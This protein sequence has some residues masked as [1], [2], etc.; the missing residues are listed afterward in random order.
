MPQWRVTRP[1]D[2]A[3]LNSGVFIAVLRRY[4]A[5]IAI[6]APIYFA[7]VVIL[8]ARRTPELGVGGILARIWPYF[9]S[10]FVGRLLLALVAAM[11]IVAIYSLIRWRQIL[12]F[13]GPSALLSAFASAIR[14]LIIRIERRVD[15]SLH[16][17]PFRRANESTVVPIHTLLD[18]LRACL[19]IAPA[20]P[21]LQL[22]L[23]A[24]RS[25]RP[26]QLILRR[27]A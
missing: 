1:V 12:A 8:G 14:R 18:Q 5:L 15:D 24:D 9:L 26:D 6:G 19:L 16:A 4:G 11:S 21:P 13:D 22:A 7:T 17:A 27:I 2:V 3:R 20:A 10:G 25:V 23:C